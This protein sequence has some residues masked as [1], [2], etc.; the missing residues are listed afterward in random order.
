MAMDFGSLGMNLR[1]T[2][3]YQTPKD[4]ILFVGVQANIYVYVGDDP[5]NRFDQEG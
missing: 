2:Y 3:R 4:P 1:K 5:V